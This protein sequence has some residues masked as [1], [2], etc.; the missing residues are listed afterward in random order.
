L[1]NILIEDSTKSIKTEDPFH[2]WS[3]YKVLFTLHPVT[4]ATLVCRRFVNY[5][6]SA[7]TLH[8]QDGI[9]TQKQIGTMGSTRSFRLVVGQVEG[10]CV[11]GPCGPDLSSKPVRASLVYGHL[12]EQ[13][14]E[15]LFSN[16]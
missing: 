3:S 4:Q 16:I 8:L 11:L 9:A 2:T 15:G 10:H 7:S 6:L 1:N 5:Q 12:T 14:L 13:S